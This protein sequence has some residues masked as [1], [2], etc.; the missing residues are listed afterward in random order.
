MN[1]FTKFTLFFFIL[2][3]LVLALPGPVNAQGPSGNDSPVIFGSNYILQSGQVV[4]D[5]VVFGGNAMLEKG[6]T[7]TGAVVTFGGDLTIDGEVRGDVT[8]FG[9]NTQ[10]R[11]GAFIGGDLNSLGGSTQVSPEATVKGSRIS[12]IG[13]LPLGLPTKIYTPTFWVDFGAGVGILSAIFSSLM[14][15][16]LAVLITL[17][18]PTPTERVAQT[19][20]TQTVISGAVG[21]LTLVVTPALFVTLAITVILIPLGLIGLLIFAIAILFGWVA[22]GLEIGKR[23][24]GLFHDHWATPVSAGMGTLI[25]SLVTSLGLILM[26]ESFWTLFC[27]GIPLLGLVL[28]ICLGGVVTSKFGTAVYD[29][30]PYRPLPPAPVALRTLA[31]VPPSDWQPPSIPPAPPV[32]PVPPSNQPSSPP[33]PPPNPEPPMG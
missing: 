8:N 30:N 3:S 15:A 13:G 22:L 7:V 25:L 19:I 26:G 21:L 20:D 2:A 4:K 5:L 12:G 10:V 1:R 9:G 24:T 11:P 17:F 6:S 33:P 18:L 14:L 32:P 27:V 29:P 23:I 16:L 28:M 31:R